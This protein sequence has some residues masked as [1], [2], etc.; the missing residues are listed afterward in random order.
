MSDYFETVILLCPKCQDIAEP[1][2][3]SVDGEVLWFFCRECNYQG[4]SD[5]FLA[6]TDQTNQNKIQE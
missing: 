2:F 1:A 4:V 3:V 5:D 6:L